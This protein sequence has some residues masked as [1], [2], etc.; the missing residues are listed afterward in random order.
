[1]KVKVL[2]DVVV[3]CEPP[4]VYAYGK[5]FAERIDS[6][7]RQLKQWVDEFNEFIRDHRSRDDMRLTVQNKYE[8][9]CSHCGYEWELDEDGPVC[10]EKA[11]AEWNAEKASA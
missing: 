9:Q 6:R 7:A 3:E 4:T 10:C 11:Q 8:D 1:M 2:V 5:T